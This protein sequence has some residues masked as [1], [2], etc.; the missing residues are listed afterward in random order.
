MIFTIDEC[1]LML[2]ALEH[3]PN[4]NTGTEMLND[5]LVATMPGNN[6]RAME[7]LKRMKEKNALQRK[8]VSEQCILLRAKIIEAKRVY[9]P[10]KIRETPK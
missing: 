7:D 3:L 6:G 8:E 10:A 4:K 9:F 2:E 5:L 1:N